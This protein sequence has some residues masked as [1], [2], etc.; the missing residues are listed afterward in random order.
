MVPLSVDLNRI[1]KFTGHRRLIVR[2]RFP[3]IAAVLA[4]TVSLA[5]PLAAQSPNGTING[6]VLDPSNRIVVGADVVAVNDVT[7]VQYTTKTNGEGFYVLPNLPPGPYRLQISEIGFKT[8]IKPDIV[9]NVQDALSINFTLPIGAFHEIVT[10]HG[11]APLVNTESAA[12]STVVDQQF[13]ENMPLNGRSFQTLITLTPGVV[14]TP[15]SNNAPGQ[16]SVNGQR[17]DANYFTVD[18]VSANFGTTVGVGSTSLFQAAGG[19]VPAFGALGGTNSL[20]SVD[21]MQEFRIQTSSFAPEYGST[22]GGQVAIVTRSGTDQFHGT[23]FDYFRNDVFDANNWFNDNEGLPRARDR[24]NDFGGVFGGPLVKGKAF[25]FFSYE[26]LRL[27]QPQSAQT[28]VPD[29]PSRLSAAVPVQP[30]LNA[31]PI[32]NGV[33][34]GSGAA[35]FDASYSN[36]SSLDTYSIRFDRVVNSHLTVFGRYSYAPSETSQRGA[37]G[38]LS[39]NSKMQFSTQTL[40]L[41]LTAGFTSHTSNELRVNYSNS[42]SEIRNGLDGFGGAV[43][44]S[45][46]LVFPSGVSSENGAFEFLIFQGG[47]G[48][49]E[50]G[51]NATSEQRQVDVVD[52]M[53]MTVGTHQIKFGVDYRWLSP[54]TSPESY[55]QDALFFTVAGAQTGIAPFVGVD[56]NQGAALLSRDVS[57]YGQDTWKLTPRLTLTYGLRWDVNPA[58]KGKQ[59]DSGPFTVL[60]LANPS[61]LT[62]AP[63]GTPLYATTYANLAP[64]IGIAF[65]VAQ[66]QDWETILRGGFGTFYDLGV[67]SLGLATSG[68]PFT[69]QEAL[70]GVQFPLSASQELPPTIT[71][72]PPITTQM[73]VADPNLK[74]PRTYQWNLALEQSLGGSQTFSATYI[75]SI[76]RKLLRQDA[77][78]APNA[79]FTNLIGVT[80]NTATS[81]YNALQLKFQRRLSGGLQA[82]ASYTFSHSIDIASDDSVVANTPAV[83]ADPSVDRGNSDFDVRH[84]FTGAL[85]YNLPSAGNS[86]L[87][88]IALNQWSLDTFFIARSASPVNISSGTTLVDGVEFLARP[89]VIPGV[90]LY[91]FGP[92]FPGG[93]SFNPAAFT[94]PISGLQGDFG[95]NVL[96]GF[97]AW[98]S[99]FSV[100]RTFQIVG[101]LSLQFRAE[102]FNVL[103]HPNFGNPSFT[104]LGEPFF[105]QST[106]IL[107]N[108]LSPGGSGGFNPLYQVGGP[109]SIQFALKFTF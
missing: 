88:K 25:F 14:L 51:K 60:N 27:S 79:N 31:Y 2:V 55:F 8:I 57:V 54:F 19:A 68:F 80:R 52:N 96:R 86:H 32:S 43:P 33:D 50:L 95:R 72:T 71:L 42:R 70:F 94:V 78:Q 22:P 48:G 91:L 77:L 10:V 93:K 76:G 24:Q 18:G 92:Q 39:T 87:A 66:K 63:R 56:S 74:L 107:A 82:L 15:A 20:V 26:G 73:F 81:A 38:A 90:P 17:T 65:Q 21:A 23:L 45:G 105:G 5:L 49:Y 98:Q 104:M 59:A 109:R 99:D 103:N 29:G 46:S 3:R 100:H 4:W 16:F 102:F 37:T 36:P 69:A 89:N 58:L 83:I 61:D 44:L 7:N 101:D 53:S 85:S 28:L 67:G 106:Q 47:I 108:G 97:G 9:L 40:T 64:R 30:F 84:S 13:V 35:Q 1:C 34:L 75:G 12:V 11:G 62:L 41:G 6:Q